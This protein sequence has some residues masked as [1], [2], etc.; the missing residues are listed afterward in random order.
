MSVFN[1]FSIST[2][3]IALCSASGSFAD[4]TADEVWANWR[5]MAA[6]MGQTLSA[7]SEDRSGNALALRDVSMTVD[8]EEG[9]ANGTIA[10]VIMTELGNGTVAITMSEEFPMDVSV[11]PAEGTPGSFSLLV[12]SPGMTTLA[13]GDPDAIAYEYSAP[14]LSISVANI[15][16]EGAP[17]DL[18]FEVAMTEATGRYAT[19]GNTPRVIE[20][21]LGA[22]AM[23][24][25]MEGKDTEGGNGSVS[26][27]ATIN[28]IASASTGTLSPFAGMTN[29]SEMLAAGFD[30]K[31]T[32]SHGAVSYLV[33]GTDADGTFSMEGSAAS[34]AFDFA[35]GP[36]GLNYGGTNAG[37]ALDISASQIPFPVVSMAMDEASGRLIMPLTVSETPDDVAL[38]M[39]IVGLAV[40]DMIWS[41]FDPNAVLPRDP[42]TLVIDLAGKANWL[43]DVFDPAYAENPGEAA[44]GQLHEANVNELRLSIAGAELTGDGAFTFDNTDP[45]M[46]KPAGAL[47]LQLVGGNGLLDKLVQMGLIPED[48]AMGARMMLGLFAR[49][50]GG[51]DTLVSTIEVQPDGA[52]LANGQRIK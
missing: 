19:S 10:E 24:V 13:S 31:G 27:S 2:A 36:D 23:T 32:M 33:N 7:G 5:S 28:D 43:V 4:V 29:L 34:G 39:R 50:G 51:E 52:V 25:S 40:N 46:P 1:R 6:D 22:K 38:S 15:E 35:L 48:Q 21:G 16:A 14:S 45:A 42:A 20:S 47:N 37:I 17:V 30:T 18:S 44:P 26:M 3:V 11:T 8:F 12:R 49:P 9:S 41:I